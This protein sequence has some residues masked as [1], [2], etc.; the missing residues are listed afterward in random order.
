MSLYK[1][2]TYRTS[3]YFPKPVKGGEFLFGLYHP[4]NRYLMRRMLVKAYWWLF[5]HCELVRGKSKVVNPDAEF[6]YRKICSMCPDGSV[7]SF[8]MGTPSEEQKISILGLEKTGKHFF[9]KYSEK[10]KARKLSENEICVLTELKGKGISPELLDS[11]ITDDFIFFRTSCVNGDNPQSQEINEEV[12]RLLK[13][14]S[15]LHLDT[16]AD[17][18]GLKTCLS[19]GDFT[20]WNMMVDNGNYNLIDWEMAAERPLGYDLF[21]FVLR[22]KL[23]MS[24]EPMKD[25]VTQN[26]NLFKSYFAWYGIED[27]SAYLKWYAYNLK[28]KYER[29]KE[30]L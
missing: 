1:F 27:Y 13:E 5:R 21:T 24:D 12:W 25:V 2:K 3:Y 11:K 9:A 7:L 28:D 22:Q 18:N 6:P 30:L 19:H 17:N 20:P 8:N 29:L 16:T 4:Y 10:P 23:L 15:G 26:D 14:L